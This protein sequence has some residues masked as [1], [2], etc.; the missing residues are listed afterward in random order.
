MA[1]SWAL[2][3]AIIALVISLVDCYFIFQNKK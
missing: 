3:I 1:A 2:W